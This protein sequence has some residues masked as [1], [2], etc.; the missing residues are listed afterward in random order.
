MEKTTVK[1]TKLSKCSGCGAKVGAGVL[2]KL[3]SDIRVHSDP[4]LLVGFDHSDDASV[5]RISDE[6]ALVQTVDFFPP[7]ADDPYLFGQIAATN[8][9][10]DIYAMGGEPKLCLNIMAVPETMPMD[11]VHDILRGGYD[12]VFEAGA[13]ITGGHSIHDDEPKYGLA[14]TGFVHPDR[15][16]TNSGAR[17]GDVLFLT[18]P[19]GIGILSTAAKADMISEAGR[20]RMYELMTVLNRSAKDV[21]VKYNVHA[22][23]D[24]TGF[25]LLGHTFEMME[26]SNAQAVID[27]RAIDLIP[28]AKELAQYG[29]IPE[30]AYRNRAFAEKTVDL[31]GIELC[32]QDM[33][34]DPQTSGGLLIAC[35]PEDAEKMF[36]ELKM[37]VPSAQRIGTVQPYDGCQRVF[38]H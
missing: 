19:L 10:S 38:L 27:T 29:L 1:L 35:S 22:C 32:I 33:L 18:K 28:E 25:G 30:G 16:L 36:D 6:L 17:P 7:I 31:S 13:L 5:Y 23:T 2:A 3:L 37:A 24:V 20:E 15:V 26:G 14:V 8:A 21:M 34:F 12:K 4:N 9:L 11:A